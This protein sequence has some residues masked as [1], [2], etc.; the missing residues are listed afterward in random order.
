[1]PPARSTRKR[2]QSIAGMSI[3]VTDASGEVGSAI[4]ERLARDGAK[5]IIHYGHDKQRADA[6][7]ERIDGRGWIVQADL[8][9]V[10]GATRLWGSAVSIAGRIHALVNCAEIRSRV[11]VDAKLADWHT[12]WRRE[13]QVNVFAAADLCRAAISD[14]RAQG[15]GRIVNLANCAAQRGYSRDALPYGSSKAALVNLSKS[16]ARSFGA[17]GILAVTVA[18]G[19]V[20]TSMANDFIDRHDKAAAIADIPIGAMAQVDEIA[21]L[22]AFALSPSQR[23]LNGATLDA[24]GGSYIR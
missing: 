2:T 3:L 15:G 9:D 17:E 21:E 14:F 10:Q 24:N 22:V 1:V 4:A 8:E 18:P 12:A 6:L 13:F 7:L 23:S 20:Q 16:I 19:W 5:P 11:D